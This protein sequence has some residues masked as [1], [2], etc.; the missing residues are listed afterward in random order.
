MMANVL[1]ETRLVYDQ[2]KCL[3]V[4]GSCYTLVYKQHGMKNIKFDVLLTCRLGGVVVSVLATGP[5]G[6]GFK[7]G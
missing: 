4:V 3:K 2:Y 6:R 1:A 5:K 7:P